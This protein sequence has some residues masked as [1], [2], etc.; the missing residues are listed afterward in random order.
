MQAAKEAI[1]DAGVD[2]VDAH[3]RWKHD[4]WVPSKSRAPWI[5]DGLSLGKEGVPTYKV[6]GAC[7]SGA[8]AMNAGVKGVLSGLDRIVV[9]GAVEKMSGHST[10]EVTAGLMM[11]EDRLKVATSGV[12]FVGLN[13]MIA[14]EYMHRFKISHDIMAEFPVMCH[15]NALDNPKA[16]FH[17]RITVDD[18]LRSPLVADPLRLF[19]CSG[20]GDGAAVIVLAPTGRSKEIH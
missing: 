1:D 8:L 16:Q 17:K 3:I 13:A 2:R 15:E 6:E 11:A 4:V 20:I 9:V 5:F 10:P 19:D 12:T 14:R 18:V 7:A